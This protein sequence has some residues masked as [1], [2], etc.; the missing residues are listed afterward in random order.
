MTKSP[1]TAP[2]PGD[3]RNGYVFT[4][5]GTWA[6]AQPPKKKHTVRNVIL[7]I[8]V[9]SILAFGGCMAMLVGGA[10][11]VSKSIDKNASKQGG[12]SNPMPIT[13]GK[14]FEVDGFKYAAGWK[15]GKDALGDVD[16]TGLKVTNNRAS[17][18]GA[19]VEIKFWKGT[20]VLALADCT[21]EQI[22]PGTTVTLS[23]T[24]ADAMPKGYDK[25]TI[26]D[27]F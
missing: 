27:T 11:E 24:S 17:K 22:A 21:T 7:A 23:C 13:A 20:E 26:N 8:I 25:I 9:L 12:D 15:V 6:P 18:D 4:E 2:Q 14:A 3:V 19:L 1:A 16:V 5:Q 10:N